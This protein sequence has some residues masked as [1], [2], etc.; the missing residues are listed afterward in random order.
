MRKLNAKDAFNEALHEEMTRDK[1]VILMGEDLG[2]VGGNFGQFAN[3]W[4]KFGPDR[5]IH[6]SLNEAA[7]FAFGEG[8]AMA[9]L[10]PIVD[11]MCAEFGILG[12][13]AIVNYA[14]K[15]RYMTNGNWKYPVVYTFAQGGGLMAGAHHSS[16]AE[17]WFHNFPGL[18]LYVPTFPA[19]QKALLKYA[20]R[21]D[22]PVVFFSHHA[23]WPLVGEVPDGDVLLEPGKAN[24]LREGTDVTI[25]S[26]HQ[27]L[28][29]SMEA[30]EELAKEGISCEVVDIRTLVPLDKKTIRES[31][32]KTGRLMVV[33]EAYKRGGPGNDIITAVTEHKESFEALKAPV[34]Y[35]GSKDFPLPMGPGENW[36]IP[37]KEDIIAAVK[38]ML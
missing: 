27:T 26:W 23:V 29:K 21:E 31:V 38:E 34:K 33:T 18:K 28:L 10:R 14:A 25:V 6:T 19:D 37:Q 7:Q 9:G 12:L 11:C 13:D 20:I 36:I 15:Q 35:V 3:T 32:K 8:A 22:D 1:D 4:Q 30:A 16:C 17:S 2:I 24:I 5:V